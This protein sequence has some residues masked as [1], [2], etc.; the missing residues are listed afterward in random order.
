LINDKPSVRGVNNMIKRLKLGSLRTSTIIVIG[1]MVIALLIKLINVFNAPAHWDTGL[2][3]NIAVGYVERGIL[4]PLMWRFNPEWNIVTGSGSGYGIF[5]LIGW[6]KLFGISVLSGHLLMYVVGLL[7]LPVIYMVGKRFYD[8]H[9]A[10]LW[11]TAF[12]ALS[13]TFAQTFYVRMDAP[14]MLVCSLILLLHVEALRR[15]KWWMH[16]LVGVS[17]VAAL[18]VHI[19]A[20]VYAGGIA[21]YH[22]VQYVQLVIKERRIVLKSPA[23][24][25]GIGCV[26]VAAIYYVHHIAPNPDIYFMIA[27]S[28]DICTPLSWGK[29]LQRWYWLIIHQPLL[30][31][32]ML[33]AACMTAVSRRQDYLPLLGGAYL[34]L[35]ILNPPVYDAYTGHLLPLLALGIGGLFTQ[36]TKLRPGQFAQLRLIGLL[37]CVVSIVV[38]LADT[39]FTYARTYISP[40]IMYARWTSEQDAVNYDRAIDYIR[41]NIHTD[42][43]IVGYE[44][45]YLDLVDYHNYMSYKGID[46]LGVGLR[47]ETYFEFWQRE[48]PQVFFGNAM[49]DPE[50]K[51]YIEWRGDFVEVVPDLWVE[52]SLVNHTSTTTEYTEPKSGKVILS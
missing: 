28:C 52:E 9:E 16:V 24:M 36:K 34:T 39:R 21:L 6:V 41:A 42:A 44:S 38:L 18:E 47:N 5:L 19:L 48:K 11:V 45:Y 51:R 17:L 49:T 15:D 50:L 2:Y 33:G 4:T 26:V 14:N 29:E 23:V 40:S 25:C 1:F 35:L 31:I 3:L 22:A 27:R 13:G 20:A 8:S 43:V 32:F 37:I 12:F 30:S 46:K 7:N 10:G